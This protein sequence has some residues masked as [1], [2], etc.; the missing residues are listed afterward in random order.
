MLKDGHI[1]EGR[2]S[3]AAILKIQRVSRGNLD[4]GITVLLD[5][6]SSQPRFKYLY[7]IGEHTVYS[8]DSHKRSY[9]L[10]LRLSREYSIK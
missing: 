1:S 6:F 3:W 8:N 10:S 9:D 4:V 5:R 2:G 7:T